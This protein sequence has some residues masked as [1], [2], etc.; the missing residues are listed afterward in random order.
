MTEKQAKEHRTEVRAN[1]WKKW[2]KDEN[3]YKCGICAWHS[4]RAAYINEDDE[5]IKEGIIAAKKKAKEAGKTFL[6]SDCIKKLHFASEVHKKSVKGRRMD[7]CRIDKGEQRGPQEDRK[8][9]LRPK[10]SKGPRKIRCD[11]G[12]AKNQLYA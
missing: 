11:K 10:R 12:I 2:E 1:D 6:K 7:F 9:A 8:R 5:D 4:R 3:G